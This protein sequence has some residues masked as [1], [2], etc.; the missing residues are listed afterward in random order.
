MRFQ[1]WRDAAGEWRFRL[2]AA[3]G[4]IVAQGES[5]TRRVDAIRAVAMLKREVR[6]AGIDAGPLQVKPS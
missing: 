5:Y 2:V 3:N 1:V 4:E 6:H